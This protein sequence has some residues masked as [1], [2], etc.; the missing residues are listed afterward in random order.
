MLRCLKCFFWD[1]KI[2]IKWTKFKRKEFS[3][4]YEF[5]EGKEIDWRRNFRL[6][7][8]GWK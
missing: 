1:I 5:I 6:K 8:S 7:L 3:S 4:S 2:N